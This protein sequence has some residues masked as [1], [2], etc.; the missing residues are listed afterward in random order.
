MAGC[1]IHNTPVRDRTYKM[2]VQAAFYLLPKK[3]GVEQLYLYTRLNQREKLWYQGSLR[4]CYH[5][6]N[7]K[8]A[9]PAADNPMLIHCQ[10]NKNLISFGIYILRNMVINY[11]CA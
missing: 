3:S 1:H 5:S 10:E 8:K 7:M 2:P 6:A 9:V 11:S 4:I